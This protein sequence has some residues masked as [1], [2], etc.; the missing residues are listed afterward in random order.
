[1]CPEKIDTPVKAEFDQNS[2]GISGRIGRSEDDEAQPIRNARLD[3][4][5]R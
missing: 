4:E 5:N 2:N 3:G 1:V